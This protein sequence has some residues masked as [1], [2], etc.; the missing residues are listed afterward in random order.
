[1]PGVDPK[2][3]PCHLW[4]GSINTKGYGQFSP[5][6]GRHGRKEVAHK[7]IFKLLKG[8]V[9]H[10]H[11]L[12]HLCRVRRCVNE[13][14]LEPVT[15]RVNVFRGERPQ[16]RTCSRGHLL[17]PPVLGVKRVCRVCRISDRRRQKAIKRLLV[18]K[19]ENRSMKLTDAQVM[20]A[21]AARESGSPPLYVLAER[22]GVASDTLY[23]AAAGETYQ[24]LPIKDRK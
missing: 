20:E 3:G 21:R 13:N 12:D 17:P 19:P 6:G 7:F 11:D 8:Q 9:P 22:F 18:S 23:R 24:H 4:Q 15:H 1:M 14:H 2:L 16:S 5:D 10:G